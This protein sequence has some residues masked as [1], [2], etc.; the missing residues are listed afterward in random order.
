MKG[1]LKTQAPPLPL[2]VPRLRGGA[3][4]FTKAREA[5]RKPVPRLKIL[6]KELYIV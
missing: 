5:S 6:I 1:A 3:G 2:L 4:N